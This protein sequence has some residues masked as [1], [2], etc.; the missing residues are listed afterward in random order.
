M[1]RSGIGQAGSRLR[2]LSF[3]EKGQQLVDCQERAAHMVQTGFYAP[4]VEIPTFVLRAEQ[5]VERR[6]TAGVVYATPRPRKR[7][8]ARSYFEDSTCP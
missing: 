8:D 7:Y 1:N 6:L 4:E 3:P 5:V 2:G